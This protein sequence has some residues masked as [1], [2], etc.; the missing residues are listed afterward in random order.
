MHDRQA[1]SDSMRARLVPLTPHCMPN[2]GVV[3]H[4]RA[5]RATPEKS[6]D[7][8]IKRGLLLRPLE[9]A[10]AALWNAIA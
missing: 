3:P 9:L 2:L 8:G 1:V 7:R 6:R 5:V 4:Y 10:G